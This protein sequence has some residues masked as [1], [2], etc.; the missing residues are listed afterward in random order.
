VLPDY[1]VYEK[2]HTLIYS[3]GHTAVASMPPAIHPA[4]MANK[5]LFFCLVDMVIK[6]SIKLVSFVAY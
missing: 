3:I 2:I 4:D 5:G 6:V 1:Q